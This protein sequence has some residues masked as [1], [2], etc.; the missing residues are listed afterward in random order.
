MTPEPPPP[1]PPPQLTGVSPASAEPGA[2]VTLTGSAFGPPEAPPIVRF[3]LPEGG[4]PVDAQVVSHTEGE[5]VARVPP[6]N[7]FGSGGP[8]NITVTTPGGT[9]APR[10][11]LLLEPAAPTLAAVTPA[12]GIEG[13]EVVLQGAGFGRR[14]DG[15]RVHFRSAAGTGVEAPV[16][17]WSP[18]SIRVRVVGPAALGGTGER[19]V[20]VTTPWGM[21]APHAFLVGELPVVASVAPANPSP[22]SDVTVTGRAFGPREEGR[23]TLVS[24]FEGDVPGG[25]A[26]TVEPEVLSWSDTRIETRL[27]NFRDLRTTGRKQLVVE[28]SWGAGGPAMLTVSNRASVTTWTKLEPHARVDDLDEGLRLGLEARVDDPLWMLGRQWQMMEFEGEDAGSPITVRLEGVAAPIARW[29]PAGGEA[30]D[31]PA[32]V[33]LEA[34]VERERVLPPRG[35]GPSPFPGVRLAAEAGLHFLRLL[36]ARLERPDRADDYRKR[37]LREYALAPSADELA[38]ADPASRRFLSVMAGRAP[39]GARLYADLQQA[40]PENGGE[41]PDKPPVNGNDRDDVRAAIADWFA[42]CGSLFSEAQAAEA[43]AWLPERMEFRFDA[44]AGDQTLSVAEYDGGRLDW[45]AFTAA[46]PD[47]LPVGDPPAGR[48]PTAFTRTLIPAIISF[49]GMPAARWWEIEDAA[50]DFGAVSAGPSEL[51]KLLFLEFATA[52]END[53]FVVPLD[54]LPVGSLVEL[55]SVTV[56]DTFGAEIELVAFAEGAG[57]D[58]RMWELTGAGDVAT[59]RLLVPD[60][61]PATLESSPSEEVLLLRDELAN[62]AWAVERVIESPGG[63]PLNRAEEEARRRGALDEDPE[64]AA[65]G[66]PP[67]RYRLATTVPDNWI[68][69]LPHVDLGDGGAVLSRRLVRGAM[70]RE[71]SGEPIPPLGR[72]LLPGQPLALF[73]EEVPRTGARVTRGWQ[74]GRAPDGSTHLWRARRKGPGR[75]EGSSGLR[76]DHVQR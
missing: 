74:L 49:P 26:H 60:T 50:V 7:A 23:V 53:W 59:G 33:P 76:F 10:S 4:A 11:F 9:T 16:V 55:T 5:I 70:A 14:T 13:A 19:P 6:L 34:L 44:G 73:D 35:A 75:G 41:L 65:D 52:F 29:R 69:L 20:T 27:P 18:T 40:L 17:A 46:G 56:T 61:L 37:Y 39:D 45:H 71:G 62:L 64:P 38:T 25:P 66:A 48:E 58:W 42:W 57:A 43:P 15:S 68:P 47:T 8:L 67:L 63:R 36:T 32:G 30:G 3:A 31:V 22:R 24:V 28:S 2:T 1:P 12:R 54:G 72:L 21:S 51:L